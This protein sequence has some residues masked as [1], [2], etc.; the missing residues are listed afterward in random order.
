MQWHCSF[1]RGF[2]GC[3]VHEVPLVIWKDTL[4]IHSWKENHL[5][6][7]LM[8]STDLKLLQ[9]ELLLTLYSLPSFVMP[10][11]E[12]INYPTISNNEMWGG[13][14]RMRERWQEGGHMST[15]QEFA[16]FRY[17]SSEILPPVRS[18]YNSVSSIVSV[19]Q[20]WPPSSRASNTQSVPSSLTSSGSISFPSHFCS[21]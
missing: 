4:L 8:I 16:L 15:V 13:G 10:Q 12:L 9:N 2:P 17:I 5:Y 1:P 11:T 14:R 20:P 7:I 6:L 3:H 18:A 21:S 19:F